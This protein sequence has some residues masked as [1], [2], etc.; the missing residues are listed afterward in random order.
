MRKI[1]TINKKNNFDAG[2]K[3]VQ[4]CVDVV[5]MNGIDNNVETKVFPQDEKIGGYSVFKIEYFKKYLVVG[6]LDGKLFDSILKKYEIPVLVDDT[7]KYVLSL[8]NSKGTIARAALKKLR[9]GT[10]INCSPIKLNLIDVY[11]CLLRNFPDVKVYSGWFSR[12]GSQLQNALLQGSD[13]NEDSDWTKY[14]EKKG[15]ELKNIQLKIFDD[16]F[17]GGSIIIS[18][19]S[20]GFIFTN[21]II[22]EEKFIKLVN[23]IIDVLDKA[24]IIRD[25]DEEK[26]EAVIE[27]TGILYRAQG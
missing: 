7:K 19:S 11:T 8:S 17:K 25:E 6:M 3:E 23:Q 16:D 12:L 1:V 21:N 27:E 24:G 5:K 14:K 2:L 4:K 18:I 9:K 26:A 13:V 15:A 22:S 20:R 10:S